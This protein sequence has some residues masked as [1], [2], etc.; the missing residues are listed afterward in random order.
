MPPSIVSSSRPWRTAAATFGLAL[1]FFLLILHFC[2]LLYDADAY[3]HLAIARIYAE[4]GVVHQAPALRYS[5]LGTEFGDKELLLHGMLAPFAHSGEAGGRR[6][7]AVLAS[8]IFALIAGL[9][10]P[11][12]GRWAVLVPFGLF[13]GALDFSWR[14]MTGPSCSRSCCLSGWSGPWRE[15]PLG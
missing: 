4:R 15:R 5:L 8:V 2:P 10:V 3:Y 11:A 12:V 9:A 13:F 7:L 1:A 14:L 6:A